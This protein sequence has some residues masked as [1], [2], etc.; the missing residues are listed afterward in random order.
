ME[1]N[2]EE[3]WVA[4]RLASIEPLWN[5]NLARGRQ[6]L[7][8][9]LAARSPLQ[10]WLV[11]AAAILT[12]CF[13]VVAL[14]ATRALAQELWYRFILNRI[15][16]VRLD[17]SKLPLHMQVTTNGLEQRVQDL[18]EA[19]R[20]AGFTPFLP[21]ADVLSAYPTITVTGPIS[22]EQTIHV[23]DIE[24]AL[25]KGGVPDIQ[26]PPEWEG[27]QLR[28]TI[29]PMVELDYPDNV[30]IVQVRPMEL[31]IP[32][33]FDLEYFAE[34]AFRSIGVSSWEAQ[35]MSQKFA[36]HPAWLLDIPR[37]PALG[38]REVSMQKGP[39]LMIEDLDEQRATKRAT[40]ISSTS[41]RVYSV[42]TGNPDLSVKIA[43][44]LP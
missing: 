28:T 15:D 7:E 3:A 20:K 21:S 10:T 41:E 39:A 36:A 5:P 17:L 1:T 6:L 32:A 33:G 16:V 42:T 18:D 24:T 26:V 23:R 4:E 19:E 34:L 40:V 31:L 2:H 9:R 37:D 22:I 13:V 27:A 8:A 43:D 12:A 44:S 38:V 29:G 30:R 11:A 25:D 14:P 35:L